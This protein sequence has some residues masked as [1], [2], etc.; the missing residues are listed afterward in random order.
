MYLDGR[1]FTVD[2][3]G[4]KTGGNNVSLM[5]R[6]GHFH[7]QVPRHRHR[8]LSR[9]LPPRASRRKER[10][11]LERGA[12]DFILLGQFPNSSFSTQQ[13][14]TANKMLLERP[15]ASAGLRR[16]IWPYLAQEVHLCH[17]QFKGS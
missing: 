2:M 17:L 1:L 15:R 12:I 13:G 4:R 6:E 16:Q 3:E 9:L 5:T 8:T 11:M 10:K 14:Y 7:T